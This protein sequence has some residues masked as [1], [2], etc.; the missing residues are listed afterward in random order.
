MVLAARQAITSGVTGWPTSTALPHQVVQCIARSLLSV[1][2]ILSHICS[3]YRAQPNHKTKIKSS[4]LPVFTFPPVF[5]RELGGTR[6]RDDA[7]RGSSGKDVR[8]S[9]IATSINEGLA[10]QIIEPGRSSFQIER[11]IG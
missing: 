8:H 1:P 4:A 7:I 5:S 9:L 11:T 3:L 2:E 6:A 10:T